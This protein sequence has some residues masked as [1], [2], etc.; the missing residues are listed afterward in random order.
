M[1][2]KDK[3][4]YR[5][6]NKRC[7]IQKDIPVFTKAHPVQGTDQLKHLFNFEDTCSCLHTRQ[8]TQLHHDDVFIQSR[9]CVHSTSPELQV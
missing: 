4:F 2:V 7:M 6:M 1:V 5:I 9:C 8:T 3:M